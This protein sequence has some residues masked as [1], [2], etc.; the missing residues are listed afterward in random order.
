MCIRDRYNIQFSAQLLNY[1][2]SDDNVTM[3]FK[4]NG[5][6]IEFSSSIEQVSPKH[7]SSPGAIILALNIME[8]FNTGDYV[9]LFWT[10]QTGNTV[11]ATYPPQ[12]SPVCPAS[13]SLILTVQFVSAIPA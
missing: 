11:L 12:T 4:K 7:G 1:D 8:Q 10:S 9:E 5:T 13:P 6:Q 2:T 3:W